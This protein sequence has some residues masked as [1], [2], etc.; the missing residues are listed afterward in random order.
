MKHN[1]SKHHRQVLECLQHLIYKKFNR[2]LRNFY[3]EYEV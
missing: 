3:E 1:L 2:L